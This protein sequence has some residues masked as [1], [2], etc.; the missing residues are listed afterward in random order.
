MA[1]D[2]AN[3]LRDRLRQLIGAKEVLLAPG[4]SDCLSAVL[5]E[6]V[7]FQAVYMSGMV[8]S[9]TQL[10]LPDAG[11]ITMNEM[12]DNARRIAAAVDIPVIS[13]SDTG[14]GNAISAMRTVREFIGLTSVDT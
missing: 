11:L 7:G 13:D 3:R 6:K 12:V 1:I 4:T 10:G 2:K 9:F 5:V 14:F 8:T